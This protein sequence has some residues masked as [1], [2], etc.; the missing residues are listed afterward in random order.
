VGNWKELSNKRKIKTLKRYSIIIPESSP[1]RVPLECPVCG[2]LMSSFE[3]TVSYQ[4]YNCC[5]PCNTQWAFH[6]QEKW[7]KGWR[8]SQSEIKK[9]INERNNIPSFIYEV[10]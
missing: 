6:N 4:D 8:P 10:K 5:T 3:D 9:Y 2:L 1:N 7:K